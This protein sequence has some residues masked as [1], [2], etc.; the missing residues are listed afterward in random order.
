[1]KKVICYI[2]AI[3]TFIMPFTV[4]VNATETVETA[5][6]ITGEYSDNLTFVCDNNSIF[7]KTM[8]APG[9]QWSATIKIKNNSADKSLD[10][11]LQDI[12]SAIEDLRL[13]NVLGL[14]IYLDQNLV[15]D[16]LY[17]ASKKPIIDWVTLKPYESKYLQII[18]SVPTELNNNYQSLKMVSRWNFACRT[19]ENATVPSSESEPNTP[20]KTGVQYM[21]NNPAVLVA[22]VSAT[23]AIMMIII[24]CIYKKKKRK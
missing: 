2:L 20:I 13:Y 9:D 22:F 5:V 19:D 8:V 21:I 14:Q 18:V 12:E 1:M 10:V 6:S 24:Y 11:S 15:Y 16:D 4:V 17:C 7:E 3:I 23:L